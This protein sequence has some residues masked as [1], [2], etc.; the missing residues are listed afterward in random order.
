M[1]LYCR[2]QCKCAPGCEDIPPPKT[3]RS[4]CCRLNT[5]QTVSSTFQPF[6]PFSTTTAT[7]ASKENTLSQCG[8]HNPDGIGFKIG[9]SPEDT[10]FGEFP[11]MIGIF[12]EN[13]RYR[14][15]G[16]L[17]HPSI[18]LTAAHCVAQPEKYSVTA[19]EWDSSDNKELF[20]HQIRQVSS[21]KLHEKFVRA[22]LHYDIAIL[23]LETPFE[24]APNV[25]TIC[26]PP[27]DVVA[28]NEE[29]YATGWGKTKFGMKN[30][31]T[32]ILKK[33]LLPMVNNTQC[34]ENLRQTRLGNYY[35]L[36]PSFVCAG[37]KKDLDTCTGDGGG[38][39]VCPIKGTEDRYYQ[40]GITSWG[41]G[42]NTENVPGVYT[43]VAILRN[44]I[45]KQIKS[46][47]YQTEPYQLERLMSVS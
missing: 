44:W 13:G 19:G 38:P 5:N 45:D 23:Y 21:I 12:L 20:K 18:V 43:N 27:A 40:I 36:D 17:I 47:N 39:L 22:N 8:V 26:L 33:V 15:G 32:A 2:I 10:A 7:S 41:I 11:W 28:N 25:K 9:S 1:V 4:V 6:P 29:C 46:Q 31:E 3:P 24:L 34:Q 42:C 14:C 16:S 35:L 30:E 37:G